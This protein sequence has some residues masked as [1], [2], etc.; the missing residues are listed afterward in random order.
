V[1]RVLYDDQL[2]GLEL[3]NY[4]LAALIDNPIVGEHQLL[5]EKNCRDQMLIGSTS[6]D[7][8]SPRFSDRLL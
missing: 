6:N 4:Q 1:S 7:V 2:M 3:C 8:R 5:N